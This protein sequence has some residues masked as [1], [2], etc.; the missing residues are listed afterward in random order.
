MLGRQ[1]HMN[2]KKL[3]S[4][5]E[6]GLEVLTVHLEDFD[7]SRNRSGRD[8]KISGGCAQEKELPL[9]SDFD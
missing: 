9:S 2:D 7:W 5:A 8:Y 6:R 1:T 4:L 3:H